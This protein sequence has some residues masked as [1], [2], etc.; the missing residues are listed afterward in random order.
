MPFQEI[1]ALPML[2]VSLIEKLIN[3]ALRLDPESAE[4]LARLEGRVIAIEIS[5]L[6]LTLYAMP[7][8]RG[9]QLHTGLEGE[10]DVTIRGGP[11]GLA[12]MGL[13]DTPSSLFGEGVEIEGDTDLGR[14]LKQIIDGLDIDWEEQLSRLVGDVTAH[15]L[16]NL[17]RQTS[18][19]ARRSAE[20]LGRDEV[21]YLQEESRDL[22]VREEL[23]P[24]LD[25]ID[26]LRLDVDRL[27]Q[28]IA[29]LRAEMLPSDKD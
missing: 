28:R 13:S 5:G 15:Q 18:Q 9:L 29:R 24:F 11:V 17:F 10:A 21:E 14:R 4:Q 1:K 8:S 12:R 7:S 6:D 3:E 27:D 25:Q 23:E 20:T 22:V 19:W 2:A 26:T 16:G